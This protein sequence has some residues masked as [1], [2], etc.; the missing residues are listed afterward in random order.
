MMK[1]IDLGKIAWK[2]EPAPRQFSPKKATTL[3]EG[4]NSD[5]QFRN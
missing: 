2:Q 5:R 3:S 4:D 1:I